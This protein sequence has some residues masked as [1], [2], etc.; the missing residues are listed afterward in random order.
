MSSPIAL[1]L[2][3]SGAS[4]NLAVSMLIIFGS[5]KLLAE[6]FER[7]GQPGLIGEILAGILVGPAMLGWIHP[8]EFTGT[9]AGLGVMFLLFR[10]GL[11]VEARE[12]LKVG[13][14]ALLVGV[15]GVIVPFLCGWAFYLGEGKSQLESLFLGTALTAT[16][17]GITAQVLA[18]KGLLQR[19]ASRIILAAAI[20]DDVLALLVLG[21]VA[22]L[23]RGQLDVLQLSVTTAMGVTFIILIVRWGRQTVARVVG[24]L[25]ENLRVGE[26]QFALAMILMFA[27]AALAVK[28]GVAAIIGAFLAGM[29]LADAVP[30]RVHDLTRGVTELLVPFFLVDIGLHFQLSVFRDSA[31]WK[32]ALLVLPI[33]V[34]SKMFG[35]GLGAIGRGRATATRVGIGMIPRGEFCMVVAQIGLTLGAISA[36]TFAVIVFMAVV[37]AM[38]APPLL[39]VAFRGVLASPPPEE[40]VYRLG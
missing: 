16:S 3:S 36:Q 22:S 25:Q 19:T 9:M 40:E 6:L 29:A 27:L 38:L 15:S 26:A 31:S 21:V 34:L 2:P 39:K 33:A 20:I 35:C 1:L 30:K 23:A 28:I 4:V 18:A 37:A 32:L 13:G 10:V 24:K 5:A 11:E 14:T 12:L 17:V 8:S 7:L